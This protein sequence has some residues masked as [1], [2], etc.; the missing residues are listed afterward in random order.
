MIKKKFVVGSLLIALVAAFSGCNMFDK[1]E[2]NSAGRLMIDTSEPRTEVTDVTPESG[3]TTEQ[4]KPSSEKSVADILKDKAVQKKIGEIN[5]FIDSY[6]YFETDN[7][8]QEESIYDGI[9]DGLDDPY[10]V[11]YTAKEYET[12]KEDSSGEYYGVGAVVTQDTDMTVKIVRP[13]KGSPA[14][15]AGLMAEDIVVEV[16][17]EV[18]NGQDLSTVVEMIR[19]KT[20]TKAHIKI[21]RPTEAKYIEFDIERAI[22]QNVTVDY[23]ILD[24]HIGYI[25]VTQFNDNTDEE[26][27]EAVDS[28]EKA[29]VRGV[30]VDLRDN[31]GGMLQAVV[32]MCAYT[33]DGGDIVTTK[34]K[35]GEIVAKYG[36]NNEHAIK[37][38]MV[39]LVNGNSASA[40]EI[41]AGAMKDTGTAKLVGTNTFGKGIVQS[42][43][44]LSDGTAIKLTVAKYFT[45]AG[46]DIHKIGIAPDYEV[47]LESGESAV[48]VERKDDLQLQ[49]AEKII[50]EMQ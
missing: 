49:K 36:D 2:D 27:K 46:N 25:S 1:G 11:Y 34:D 12:L 22:V 38:P 10:S 43:M 32:N 18:I 6:Y 30:I 40:S 35:N 20:G 44:P 16:D 5:D 23:E 42:I 13:I 19:G 15:K 41:F 7:D 14:E 29:G 31:P 3:D 47:K 45:P 21:Y 8:K 37:V 39:V 9:M 24:N 4:D 28:L 48:G 26:Y 17:G 33:L 50:N